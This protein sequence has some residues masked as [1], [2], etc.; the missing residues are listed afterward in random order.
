MKTITAQAVSAVN[1]FLD[2]P[3]VFDNPFTIT[4]LQL[5]T[6]FHSYFLN[7]W[8]ILISDN[9]V[10]IYYHLTNLCNLKGHVWAYSLKFRRTYSLYLFIF[11]IVLI[12][13]LYSLFVKFSSSILHNERW[14]FQWSLMWHERIHSLWL[15]AWVN[16]SFY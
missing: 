12:T 9:I 5:Y 13:P 1:L 7:W 14:E 16:Q 8:D 6:L 10:I 2:L 4:R 11:S 15:K 3:Y